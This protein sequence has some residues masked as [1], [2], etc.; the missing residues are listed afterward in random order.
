MRRVGRGGA[1]KAQEAKRELPDILEG[2]APITAALGTLYAYDLT[3]SMEARVKGAGAL[4]A[5]FGKAME[6][7]FPREAERKAA[8][9]ATENE[10]RKLAGGKDAAQ[11]AAASELLAAW[12]KGA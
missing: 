12:D 3:L 9:D 1:E 7:R 4:L 2:R 10:L 5:D 11:S 6:G 8:L